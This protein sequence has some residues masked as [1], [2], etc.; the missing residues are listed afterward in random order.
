M[1][2][3][4]RKPTRLSG[5]DY[6]QNGAYFVTICCADRKPL[7]SSVIVGHGLAPAAIRLSALGMIAHKQLL[8]LPERFPTIHIDNYVIM[9]NHIHLLISIN[10]SAA[11]LSH[12]TIVDVIRVYKSLTTRKCKQVSF[13][14]KLFQSSF[15]DHIIRGQQ[16]YDAIWEYIDNNPAR[17]AEDH[18]YIEE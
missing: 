16:D 10:N 3:P 17:W 18:L 5:Y 12:V 13:L 2:L 15:H 1:S 9:P 8:L 7:L 6:G 11:S 14:N 4:K